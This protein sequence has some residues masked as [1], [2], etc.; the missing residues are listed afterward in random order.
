MKKF[1]WIVLLLC[2]NVSGKADGCHKFAEF[3]AVCR[4]YRYHCIYVF[5]IIAPDNWVWKKNTNIFNIFP[6]NVP[7]NTIA[8]I[9]Q[10]NC[11]QTTKKYVPVHSMWLIRVFV[12]LAN[13][14][15]WHCL[16]I[17]CSW[18]N[19]N[20]PD[21]YPT[22]DSNLENKVCYCN[23]PHDDELYNVFISNT[24]KA[25]SFSN[26]IYFKINRVQGKDKTFDAEKTLK[27]DSAYDRSSKLDKTV[28][29]QPEFY[30]GSRKRGHKETSEHA[31]GGFTTT[32][33]SAK[34][35]FLSGR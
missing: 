33:K 20:S 17:D 8:K 6:L 27:E 12:D 31:I 10:S 13:T 21:R 1:Q 14:D 28:S 34:S 15:E 32:R 2:D 22:Q 5:H 24:I 19:R 3:L 30:G 29:K 26:R 18:K 25:G 35:K 23:Q 4:K 9:L 11:R 7:Y 16:T